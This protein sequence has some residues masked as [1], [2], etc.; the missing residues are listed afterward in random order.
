MRERGRQLTREWASLNEFRKFLKNTMKV[1]NVSS[2]Y[3]QLKNVVNQLHAAY[4]T[5]EEWLAIAPDERPSFYYGTRSEI[6]YILYWVRVTG[7]CNDDAKNASSR[8]KELIRYIASRR[9]VYLASLP[10]KFGFLTEEEA[11]FIV[12]KDASKKGVLNKLA[13]HV[14]GVMKPLSQFTDQDVELADFVRPGD[15]RYNSKLL[16]DIL[17]GLGYKE[18][19][20]KRR[21]RTMF[22]ECCDHEKWGEIAQEYRQH[23]KRSMALDYYIRKSGG[24]LYKLFKWL[25][26][27]GESNAALL[28][29]TDFLDLFDYFSAD[30]NGEEF[31]AKYK[32][33][34]LSYVKGFFEWGIGMNSFFPQQLNWPNDV[35]SG[36]HRKAQND[37]YAG[38]GLAFDDA[39]YPYRMK[40]AIE[41]LTPENDIEALCRAFWLIIASSPV[42][43]SYLLN[44]QEQD[45]VLPMPNAPAAVGLYSPY[46]G[47]E[48]SNRRNGQFPIL[49]P[50]G[51]KALE[52]L[53]QRVKE[54]GFRP[55]WNERAESSYV[56]L[57]QLSD[58]PWVLKDAQVDRFF[59]KVAKSI[60]YGDKKGKAHGYRHYLITHIA[61]ETGNSELA[62]LAAGHEN[63]TIL[64]RY[65]RS[66]L[67][68]NAFL[69]AAIKKYQEKELGGR[70]IWRI[71]EALADDQ[72]EPNE[73]IKAM[74]SDELT[75]DEFFSQFGL[76][77]P[78]GVGKCL[79]QGACEYE[80]KCF[81]CRHFAIHRDEAPQAFQVLAKLTEYMWFVREKSRNFSYKNSK[82]ASLITQISLLVDMIRHFGY[83]DEQIE[84]E[85]LQHLSKFKQ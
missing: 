16:R 27:R 26:K 60:G 13:I 1:R 65:L 55:I 36:I 38:D 59:N 75:M 5:P 66:N 63:H 68:R 81:S 17:Y 35:Y 78:T 19:T 14:L 34:R 67:S 71:F 64:N 25:D 61:I 40:N 62:R 80:A 73:L 48:K 39:E 31:S 20:G 50:S 32:G 21:L 46:P 11:A 44:L 47:I 83:N 3:C 52:F 10:V 49:D 51:L 58:Y 8:R 57:F 84:F 79:V 37:T 45:C 9:R 56:H 23:L 2:V 70:F 29:Y 15:S 6:L 4:P 28:N 24:A 85:L 53:Q 74:G 12:S 30:E 7:F 18:T 54:K 82:A 42:R 77:A 69:F 72:T 22:D 43:K 41:D 76:P 33:N